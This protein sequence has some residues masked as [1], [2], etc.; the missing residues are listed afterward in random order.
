MNTHHLELFYYVAKH[1]GISQALRYIPY[2]IQQPALSSQL[3]ALEEALGTKLFQRRPFALSP[4]GEELYA[5]I[6]PF[7]GNLQAVA[8][9]IS[10]YENPRLR[11]AST[12]TIVRDYFPF[13]LSLVREEFPNLR[14]AVKEIES[15]QM[16]DYLRRQEVDLAVSF[17]EGKPPSGLRYQSLVKLPLHLIVPADSPHKSALPAIR[18]S[19]AEG[20]NLVSLPA[21]TTP[22]RTFQ[23]A[24]KRHQLAWSPEIEVN[25]LGLIHAYVAEGF[26]V[27][28]SVDIPNLALPESIRALP[29]RQFP[30]LEIGIFWQ[31]KLTPVASHFA[32]EVRQRIDHMMQQTE[33]TA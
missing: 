17:C 7:F 30:K 21:T 12:P 31:G 15:T 10:G 9:R 22:H 16:E 2:G 3:I 13:Y 11:I 6:S 29:L 23:K 18:Q 5:F 32:K 33:D 20:V 19:I 4:A 1:G 28:L 24:L 25:S 8:D 26:G 27:G 14:I